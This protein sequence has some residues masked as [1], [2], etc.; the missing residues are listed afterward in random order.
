MADS[1]FKAWS[2]AR[3]IPRNPPRLS[4]DRTRFAF[5]RFA[6]VPKE[7]HGLLFNWNYH[8]CRFASHIQ[9]IWSGTIRH[10]RSIFMAPVKS[11]ES[12]LA[13]SLT[14]VGPLWLTKTEV[15]RE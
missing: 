2:V 12:H 13:P 3:V 11:V 15:P 8:V 14:N 10:I 5:R 4:E 6:V 1:I 7:G 9:A